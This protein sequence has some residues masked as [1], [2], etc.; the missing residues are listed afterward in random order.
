[1]NAVGIQPA[2]GE[3]AAGMPWASSKMAA[4]MGEWRMILFAGTW[5]AAP[6]QSYP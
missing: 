1:M 4:R 2:A 3:Q 5:P 6:G